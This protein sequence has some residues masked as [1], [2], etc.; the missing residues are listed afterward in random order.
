MKTKATDGRPDAENFRDGGVGGVEAKSPLELQGHST[1]PEIDSH[2]KVQELQSE[3][4]EGP[5]VDP[6]REQ[7][8]KPVELA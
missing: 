1:V 7:K 8:M 3:S 2:K 6:A 5:H 4:V